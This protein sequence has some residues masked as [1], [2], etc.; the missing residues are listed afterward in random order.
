[1]EIKTGVERTSHKG[2]RKFD[3]VGNCDPCC[4]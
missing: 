4:G 1:M 2:P 3:G